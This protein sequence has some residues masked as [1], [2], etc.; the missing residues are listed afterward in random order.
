LP[1]GGDEKLNHNT[2]PPMVGG[3]V[4]FFD[5]VQKGNLQERNTDF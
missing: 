3:A 5:L 2:A 1:S 4:L